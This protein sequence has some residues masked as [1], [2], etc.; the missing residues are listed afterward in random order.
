VSITNLFPV[1]F[2]ADVSF[3]REKY[4][5]RM[6]GSDSADARVELHSEGDGTQLPDLF[7]E[8][9][10]PN[11]V[12]AFYMLA[13]AMECA[14]ILEDPDTGVTSLYLVARDEKGRDL[15]P[16]LLGKDLRS[17]V[18]EASSTTFDSVSSCVKRL[19]Q[20]QYLHRTKRDEILRNI[21]SVIDGIRVET[22]NPLDKTYKAYVQARTLAEET[23]ASL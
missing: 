12:L 13:H 1:R 14:R 22:K 15:E 2:A 8:D 10:N 19:L 17:A 11:K 23:L 6:R 21:E 18:A 20:T 3:L 7:L 9:I 16:L 4:V 5:L